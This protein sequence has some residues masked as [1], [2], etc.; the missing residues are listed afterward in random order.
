[1]TNIDC[2]ITVAYLTPAGT[3]V[4]V[5]I[6][7]NQETCYAYT[8]HKETYCNKLELINRNHHLTRQPSLKSHWSTNIIKPKEA[9]SHSAQKAIP[10]AAT[11]AYPNTHEVNVDAEQ[12]TDL[13]EYKDQNIILKETCSQ[14][15]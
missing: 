4:S 10:C 14:S 13:M 12:Q 7:P 11:A 3:N 9:E 1:M 2:A 8:T 6:M 5:D 15:T